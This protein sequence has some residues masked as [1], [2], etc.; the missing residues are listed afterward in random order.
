MEPV[1]AS[2]DVDDSLDTNVGLA[3]DWVSENDLGKPL[4]VICLELI[5]GSRPEVK[6]EEEVFEE[7]DFQRD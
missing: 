7:L 4:D 6:V 3:E 1:E 5:V 2:E